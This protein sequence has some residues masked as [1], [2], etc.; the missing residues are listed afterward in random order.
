MIDNKKA[1]KYV[2]QFNKIGLLPVGSYGRSSHEKDYNDLDFITF[3][4]LK[5][6]YVLILA[7]YPKATIEVFKM[8]EK[9]LQ[10][11]ING[12]VID[13]WKTDRDNFDTV[14]LERTLTKEK[15]IYISKFLK[16]WSK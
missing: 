11:V 7:I 9:Y 6:I 8:G 1:K 12:D 3:E 2:S 13:I 15:R 16:K 5:E 14:Y 10:V 4:S